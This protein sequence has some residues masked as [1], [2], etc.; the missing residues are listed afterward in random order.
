MRGDGVW[1]GAVRPA[2]A[3]KKSVRV[4]QQE[5][6]A[7]IPLKQRFF[8]VK[9]RKCGSRTY[10][11]LTNTNKGTLTNEGLYKPE[12]LDRGPNQSSGFVRRYFFDP[13]RFGFTVPFCSYYDKLCM[14]A[15][16][17]VI[18]VDAGVVSI[19]QVGFSV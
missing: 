10:A 2:P 9:E 4:R 1:A 19:Q 3:L 15:L 5:G 6:N 17:P 11:Y 16:Y 18:T 7:F 8:N 13:V 14:T 12:S